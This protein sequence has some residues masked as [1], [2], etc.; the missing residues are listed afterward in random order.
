VTKFLDFKVNLKF[1]AEKNFFCNKKSGKKFIISDDSI[2]LSRV[3]ST[4]EP[5]TTSSSSTSDESKSGSSSSLMNGKSRNSSGSKKSSSPIKISNPPQ[6]CTWCAETK[7]ALKYVLPTANGKKE[8]CSES[9][10]A[11]FRKAYNKGACVECDNVIRPNAPSRDCC[12]TFCLNK[13]KKKAAA[14][15]GSPSTSQTKSLN[16]NNNNLSNNNKQKSVEANNN[17]PIKEHYG[18]TT[19]ISPMFQ[20]EA[21][22]VFDWKEYLKVR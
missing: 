21:F 7:T 16:N 13:N 4:P 6:N 2:K 19:K 17:N 8:F 3:M 20:Y 11:E 14:S 12:S 1:F 10:I 15:G 18:T 5:E 22:H 9:C